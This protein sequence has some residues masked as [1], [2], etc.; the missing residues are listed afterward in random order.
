MLMDLFIKV[1]ILKDEDFY[2][3]RILR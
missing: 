2:K 1:I 3:T